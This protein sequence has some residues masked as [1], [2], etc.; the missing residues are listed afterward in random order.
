M[1]HRLW[2]KSWTT[3]Y[4]EGYPVGNGRIAAM[5]L[6]HPE[7]TR[8][9]LNHEWMWRGEN[10]F[11]TFPDVS[12]HLPE[13]RKA[14]LE[15]DFLQGTILANEYLG[16]LG[17]VSGQ[18]NRVDPY[19]PVGDIF[20][21]TD[22]G[23]A[24]DYVRS[25][26]LDTGLSE[27][28]FTAPG[29]VIRERLFISAADGCLV[30]KV[31]SEAPADFRIRL[32]RIDDPR[33][34]LTFTPAPDGMTMEGQFK[35]GISF[36]A[37]CRLS[38]D[39][40]ATVTDCMEVTGSTEITLLAQIGTDAK[41]GSP[42]DEMIFPDGGD[43][44]T[45]FAAH[46]KRFAELR[47]DAV[48]D[49]DVEDN[50]HL[51]TDERIARFREGN[52]PSLPLL[53]FEYGRYLMVS[54]SSGEL[55]INLQGK[56][57]QDLQPPWDADY[58]LDVNLQMCYWFA[59]T[60]GLRQAANTLF[61]LIESYV[62]YGREMAK[63]LYGCKGFTFCIQTD[64]WGRVTPEAKGWSVW[65]G[66]AP[67]L[68]QHMFQHWRYTKDLDFLRTRCYPYLRECAAF[69][70]D[71]L[72]EQN[73]ELWV[74]PSQSPENRFEGTGFWPVSIGYNAAMDVELITELL[75]SAIESAQ[76]LG[77]DEDKVATWQD[78][79][80]RL[81]KL[82]VDSQ[83]R[84]NEWDSEERRE[85]E[86]GHRHLSHLYG[87]YPS[88]LFAPDSPEWKASEISLDDRLRHGGGHTGWSRSWVACIM[89]RLGRAE[90][91]W[92]H[93]IEL[94]GSFATSS[95]LDL[96]PP[97]IFQI[98]GNMGGTACV[99]EMLLNS[100]PGELRLLPA[101]PKDWQSGRVSRFCAQDGVTV[102]FAWE[103][104]KLTACTLEAPESTSLRVISGELDVT[105]QLEAGVPCE[106]LV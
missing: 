104:G 15:G 99:C 36:A 55:P 85:V 13:I 68:G 8:I 5:L 56:W 77:V 103:C 61:N 87:L 72:I 42:F 33:C 14:L 95:L 59:E 76:I 94:I 65:V 73:G 88:L 1:K 64:V 101:L 54:G 44:D 62:P 48:L 29:G 91:A 69:Y 93:F 11:R 52:E 82:T 67:W 51:P 46:V 7:A 41:G 10:R 63:N 23:D 70:E 98:D 22:P 6:G 38:T 47:G 106:L 53:Y 34:T 3:D 78:I 102:S 96:C 97:R 18:E 25:L 100:R 92:H 84:L 79:L 21:E 81:P 66:A 80:A 28:S 49:V 9:A 16:G 40:A 30:L 17:G 43:F 39:G 32:S 83:G 57:N 60:L 19:Q 35:D 27:V 2:H 58:H 86:P 90:E 71:Y 75:L 105:V 50:D 37:A 74:V 4:I 31:T 20:V 45:L 26:D 12:E 24:A 89:A